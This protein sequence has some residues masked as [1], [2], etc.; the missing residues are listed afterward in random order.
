M[1]ADEM[2]KLEYLHDAILSEIAFVCA[3]DSKNIKM[4]AIC[5]ED[6]GYHDWSGKS[7]VV[8]FSNI[9]RV[10]AILFGHVAGHD[11]VNSIS[12]G[13]S[14]DMQRCVEELCGLGVAPPKAFLRITLHSGSELEI[15]CDGFA[16]DV[17]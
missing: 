15:A 12:E 10:S 4:T 14:A 3:G 8:T 16:I 2:G 5:D 1:K 17:S 6:C 9:I 11:I 13:V 7:V